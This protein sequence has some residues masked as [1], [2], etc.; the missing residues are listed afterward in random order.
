MGYSK[1]LAGLSS[2]LDAKAPNRARARSAQSADIP[3]KS[4]HVKSGRVEGRLGSKPEKPNA[5]N[6]FPLC[7]RE[8]TLR[9]AVAMSV[10]CQQETRLIGALMRLSR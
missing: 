4:R 6:C 1:T 9:N 8:R 3:F 2:S 7:A 10:S 5:S